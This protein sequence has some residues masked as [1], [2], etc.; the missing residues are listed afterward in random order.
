MH[1]GDLPYIWGDIVRDPA[2]QGANQEAAKLS[3][4]MMTYWTNFA[5]TGYEIRKPARPSA[6]GT[7]GGAVLSRF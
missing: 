7:I 1:G 6:K 4:K 5:K 2:N 3:F